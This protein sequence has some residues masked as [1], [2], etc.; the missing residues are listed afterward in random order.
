[1]SG[2]A[3]V[4]TGLAVINGAAQQPAAQ[5]PA[6]GQAGQAG[7]QGTPQ[8]N[9]KDRGEYDIYSQIT[10]TQDP[11]KRLDLLNQWQTKYPQSDFAQDRLQYFVATLGQIAANDPSV[12][13]QLIDK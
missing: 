11:K 5:Q 12:R 10:Q 4:F 9:Y 6:A 3:L 2:L 8:K 7:Q 1:M 13:Q